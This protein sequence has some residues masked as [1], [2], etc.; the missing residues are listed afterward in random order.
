M[1]MASCPNTDALMGRVIVPCLVD[2]GFM[3]SIVTESF[4]LEQFSPWGH[5]RLQSCHGW[6]LQAANSLP[7][8][9]T[10]YLELDVVLCGKVAHCCGNLVVK[11]SPGTASSVTGILRINVICR[12]YRELFGSHGLSLFNLPLVILAPGPIIEALQQC[13]KATTHNH[14]E[15]RGA[16][17][18]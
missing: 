3:V 4:F 7:I 15:F 13:H 18:V 5:N 2:T 14:D 17:R 6:Q 8:P 1:L 12:C 10:G 16:V 11:D 9:Y